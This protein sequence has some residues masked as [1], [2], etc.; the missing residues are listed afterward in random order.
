[1]RFVNCV[2]EIKICLEYASLVVGQNGLK[3]VISFYS[4]S[5]FLV[6]RWQNKN[7]QPN[8][9]LQQQKITNS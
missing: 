9:S 7:Q 8:K 5:F 1:M 2:S 3:L 6:A 4:N